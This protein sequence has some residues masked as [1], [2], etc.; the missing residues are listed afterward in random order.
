MIKKKL[1]ASIA[2]SALTITVIPLLA[3]HV[4]SVKAENGLPSSLSCEYYFDDENGYTSLRDINSSILNSTFDSNYKTWGT[5]TGKYISSGKTCYY[6]QSTDKYGNSGATLIYNAATTDME[7]GN[8]VTIT[9]GSGTTYS[10]APQLVGTTLTLNYENNPSPVVTKQV[11]YDDFHPLDNTE[12]IITGPVYVELSDVYVYSVTNQSTLL[13]FGN[14]HLVTAFYGSSTTQTNVKSAF[15]NCLEGYANVKGFI[16]IYNGN[17]QLYVRDP[18]DVETLSDPQNELTGIYLGSGY[19]TEYNLYES[20]VA[21]SVYA[22]WSLTGDTLLDSNDVTFTGFDNTTSGNQTITVSYESFEVTYDI[23]VSDE[24]VGLSSFDLATSSFSCG[25]YNTG[26]YGTYSKLG[27]YRIVDNKNNTYNLLPN[28][29]VNDSGININAEEGSL[30]SYDSYRNMSSF[31]ITY[32]TSGGSSNKPSVSF[33]EQ[34]YDGKGTNVLDY[35]T[36]SKTV[37]FNLY[38]QDVNYFKIK[39]GDCIFTIEN[40]HIEYFDTLTTNGD[41]LVYDTDFTNY[42]INPTVFT[43]ELVDGVSS[44]TVPVDVDI[45]GN[46]YTVNEYRTYTYYSYEYAYDHPSMVSQIAMTD[47]V[48]VANYYTIFKE[49]PANYCYKSNYY[50]Y[51]SVF[52]NLTRCV[53]EYSKT[54]GYAQSVPYANNPPLYYEFDIALSNSYSN[55]SRGAGRVVAW[56][57]GFQ[58]TYGYDGSPVCTFTDDHYSTF[59]EFNNL[60]GWNKRFDSELLFNLVHWKQSTIVSL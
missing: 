38:G 14:E 21:P 29:E 3:I 41:T 1:I 26:N 52:G 56:K 40:V 59:Q 35:S 57:Y 39:G 50:T 15:T 5:I 37:N 6:V 11:T 9:G 58:S 46:K 55:S 60:G 23:T 31:S 33:G 43:G 19:K 7:V 28:D 8:V 51:S 12:T 22:T 54:S 47:P 2:L 17:F 18:N 36:T 30:F 53:S 48:D 24:A 34:N 45:V 16:S 25:S 49:F 42:R 13:D 32:K 20:F 27:Y 44:V 4:L 10:G